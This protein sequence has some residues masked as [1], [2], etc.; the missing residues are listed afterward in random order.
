MFLSAQ[1]PLV[2]VDI[3][4]H[5]IKLAQL[6]PSGKNYE[7]MNFAIMPLEYESIIDGV[8]QNMDN[9]V[10]SLRNL[11]KAENI[12][13]QYAVASVAGEAVIIKK[14][15]LPYMTDAELEDSIYQE[16]EQYIPFD[17][18][19]VRIDF[20][21]L[22]SPG[23]N[24]KAPVV[25]EPGEEMEVLLVAVQNEIIDLRADI[26][27]EAGLKPCIIDLDVFAM[28]NAAGLV[29]DLDQMGTVALIDLG[30]SF[31]HV[32]IL[33]DGISTFTRDI[34]QGGVACTE[35]LMSAF[36]LSFKE[37]E[38]V[39]QGHL[40]PELEMNAVVNYIVQS[41]DK[42]LEDVKKSF[43]FFQSTTNEKVE[44]VLLCGGG[45][46]IHGVQDLF[47]EK[48]GIPVDTLDLTPALK[49]SSRKFDRETI[50]Q[51]GPIATVALGLATRKFDYK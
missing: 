20:Q 40:K 38:A 2:S 25:P 13:S 50:S 15:K 19:D 4:S 48:L 28:V 24:G 17:I 27:M 33:V 35:S 36:S 30:S 18:D 1:T 44:E 39:K 7:L 41:F 5:S 49:F 8:V 31:T 21:K 9:V 47:F 37:A 6:H 34:P 16:A 26:L 23:R 43:D 46:L 12:T 29:R 22:G 51:M 42:I 3:G 14:I 32:N 11:L 45:A 10:E